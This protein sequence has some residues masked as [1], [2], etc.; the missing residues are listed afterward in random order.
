LRA[1]RTSVELKGRFGV[2]RYPWT[3]LRGWFLKRAKSSPAPP[4][5]GPA[6]RLWLRSGLRP[7]LDVLEGELTALNARQLT[8]RHP[9]LGELAIPRSVAVRLKPLAEKR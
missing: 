4:G 9:L 5:R 3:S 7:A 6:V 8:L 1:D 2:R